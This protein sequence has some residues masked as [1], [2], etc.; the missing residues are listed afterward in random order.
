MKGIEIL[1]KYWGYNSFRPLQANIVSDVING[2]DCLALLPTGGGKSICFQVPG[3]AREGMTIVISPLIALMED[4]VTHLKKVGLRAA[5]ITSAMTFREIDISL[6]NAVFGGLDFLYVSP[7]RI[8]TSIFLARIE[9]MNVGLLVVDEAHCISTWGHDFRPTYAKIGELRSFLNHVPIIALTATAT[10]K[11][12]A[13][14]IEK[15]KLKN[16]CIH[17]ASFERENLNYSLYPVENKIARILSY[18]KSAPNTSGI[19]YCRTRKNVKE[20]A[21]T[22]QNQGVKCGIYHGGMTADDRSKS[23]KNWM[24]DQPKL[25]IATNAFGMGIDKPNVRY[26]IHYDFPE[27]LEA[28]YQEAGRGGRDGE[29]AMAITYYELQDIQA[30]KEQYETKFPPQEEVTR[31]YRALCSYLKIAIG[32]GKDESYPVDVFQLSKDYSIDS[33]LLFNALKLLENNGDL[34]FS[35]AFFKPTNLKF[36]IGNSELYNIQVQQS[37]LIPLTT[38]LT[39][40]FP[41]IFDQFKTINEVSIMKQLKITKENLKE[42]LHNLEQQGI[43]EIN[44]QSNLPSV[45]FLHERLPD[46]YLNLSYTIYKERKFNALEKLKAMLEFIEHKKCRSLMLLNYFGQTGKE[47]GHCDHCI[48]ENFEQHS[49]NIEQE[50]ILYISEAKTFNEICTAFPI[51]IN[52]LKDLIRRLQHDKKL[53]YNNGVFL[54]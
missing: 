26:V 50:L 30:L 1:E 8:Q 51:E 49:V 6:D 2:H 36:N 33:Q 48:Q 18:C 52:K 16:P 46:D 14:I 9:K 10:E 54:S 19:I 47:C 5:A 42:Q 39:R 37:K 24:D 27:T 43:I 45:L 53:T 23:L 40:N 15:L 4:Q 13:D 44:F 17:E 21:I 25:I 28:Y 35:P 29:K 34:S 7:E 11:V 32:S 20:V 22:L 12:R 38:F 41:G 3:I 31:V